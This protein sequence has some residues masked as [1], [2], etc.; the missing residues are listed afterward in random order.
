M[1]VSGQ[2]HTPAALPSGRS[3]GTHWIGGWVGPRAGLDA[4]VKRKIP[5]PYR[6]SNSPPPDH[7]ARS[8]ALCHWATPAPLNYCNNPGVPRSFRTGRLERE[9]QMVQLSATRCSCDT[10]LWVSLARF[11]AIT[12]CVAPQRMFIVVYFVIETVRKL[13]DTPS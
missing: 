3:P 9:L 10:I 11:A 13:L 2:L 5:T 8:P 1:Q 6:D 4:V 7:P 12:L